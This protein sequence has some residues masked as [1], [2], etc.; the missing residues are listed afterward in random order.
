MNKFLVLSP[1]DFVLVF[2]LFH[3]WS[4]LRNF[5]NIRLG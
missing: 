3:S 2:V 5:V 1:E 4:E